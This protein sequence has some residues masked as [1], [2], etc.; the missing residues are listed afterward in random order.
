LTVVFD[1]GIW[2]SAFRFGGPPLEALDHAIVR[3]EVAICRQIIDEICAVFGRKFGQSH[4]DVLQALQPYLVDAIS[5]QVAG[6]LRGVCRDPH[7][8]MILECAADAGAELIIS[9]DRDLLVLGNYQNTRIITVRQY[10][11][12]YLQPATP[13]T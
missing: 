5:V 3:Y 9:G 7:D 4:A 8:D 12:T 6:E 1:S 2:I 11:N 13:S 10:L